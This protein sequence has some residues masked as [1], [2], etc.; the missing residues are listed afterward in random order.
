MCVA[1]LPRV[2]KS[3]RTGAQFW[4]RIRGPST[5]TSVLWCR[6]VI[7][8]APLYHRPSVLTGQTMP[9][10]WP[11]AQLSPRLIAPPP[12]MWPT[13]CILLSSIHLMS[14]ALLR[15]EWQVVVRLSLPPQP[16]TLSFWCI[17]VWQVLPTTWR[18][19]GSASSTLQMLQWRVL[20]A[21]STLTRWRPTQCIAFKTETTSK[22][23]MAST[24]P[25]F[26]PQE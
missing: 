20:V 13:E 2:S 22:Q 8:P 1:R 9:P 15:G 24:V 23:S 19:A 11:L 6:A 12:P 4:P 5:C 14:H 26:R 25:C 18:L 21:S 10:T 16:T 7:L 17:L 3:F